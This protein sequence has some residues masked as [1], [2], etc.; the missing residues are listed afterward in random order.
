VLD[1]LVSEE[2]ARLE[3]AGSFYTGT[4]SDV[5]EERFGKAQYDCVKS[6]LSI[7]SAKLSCSQHIYVPCATHEV[8]VHLT[9]VGACRG[10]RVNSNAVP[11][12]L[13]KKKAS[14]PNFERRDRYATR[15]ICG[16]MQVHGALLDWRNVLKIWRLRRDFQSAPLQTVFIA[17]VSRG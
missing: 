10:A 11:I 4:V 8:S 12:R 7:E 6:G 17:M 14:G 5:L 9:T 16:G 15:L 3:P 2:V 13:R 1:L